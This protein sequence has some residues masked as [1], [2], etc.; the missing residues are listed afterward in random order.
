MISGG[1]YLKARQIQNSKIAH[2][3]P[4]VREIWDWLIKEANHKDVKHHGM[5]IS[6]GQCVRSYRD[7]M[8]GLHWMVGWRK[9][10]YSKHDCETAMKWLKKED[11][12]T[13][14]KT[15]RGM[16]LTVVNY[17]TYQRPENYENHIC[18]RTAT[19]RKPQTSDTINKNEK[20]EKNK[21]KSTAKAV[22]KL[23]ELSDKLYFDKTFVSAPKFVNWLRSRKQNDSAIA[24]TLRQLI[25]HGKFE[26]DTHA[27][28]YGCKVM[29][30]ENQN[31]NEADYVKEAQRQQRALEDY[32]GIGGID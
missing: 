26:S 24:H 29:G 13:T 3:P 19:T 25:K 27:W 8:E 23:K 30:I 16:I 6:R 28:A 1:Y 4:H 2:A 20:N 12:L 15:T 14:R 9:M 17:D 31:Y 7:I 10:K 11:M 32:I 21:E 18:A 22:P 5:K